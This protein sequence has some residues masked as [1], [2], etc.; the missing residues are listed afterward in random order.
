MESDSTG[1]LSDYSHIKLRP[2]PRD[3]TTSGGG[4]DGGGGDGEEAIDQCLLVNEN[5]TLEEFERCPFWKKSKIVPPK[6]STI[7]VNP[8][9]INGRLGVIEDGGGELLGY[10]PTRFNFLRL[11]IE[12]GGS[13][14][15]E[16]SGSTTTPVPSVRVSLSSQ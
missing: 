15:G 2:N 12:Q 11:C 14:A 1:H 13:Y 8:T 5:I 7:H 16:V 6:G 9:V 10:L 4:E 3:G